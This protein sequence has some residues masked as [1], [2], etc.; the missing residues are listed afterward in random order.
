MK[1]QIQEYIKECDKNI[2]DKNISKEYLEDIKI[3][4]SFFQHERLIHLLVTFFVA[5]CA[6]TFFITSIYINNIYFL[7]I[8]L[9]FL[10]LFI[11][12]IFHYFFLE[13]NV[14]KLY[15]MYKDA[16]NIYYKK[17]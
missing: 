15:I 17:K 5:I 12:Y 4:I 11:P 9:L 2:K 3:H 13:N 10:V 1:K 8:F 14:Q 6:L 16:N 7:I